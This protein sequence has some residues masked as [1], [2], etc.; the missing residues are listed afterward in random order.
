MQQR[1]AD[2]GQHAQRAIGLLPPAR[3]VLRAARRALRSTACRSPCWYSSATG[4]TVGQEPLLP[5]FVLAAL[6]PLVRGVTLGACAD[7]CAP[8]AGCP[9]GPRS[10]TRRGRSSSS[11]SLTTSRCC[12]CT[13][14]GRPTATAQTGAPSTSCRSACLRAKAPLFGVG[15]PNPLGQARASAPRRGKR[16]AWRHVCGGTACATQCFA[17]GSSG[18]RHCD[19]RDTLMTLPGPFGALRLH[20]ASTVAS[21]CPCSTRA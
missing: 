15:A 19:T 21:A 7:A 17:A 3:Q 20:H 9:T 5:L 16:C 2:G 12:T 10:R 6:L 14:S 11:R 18:A 8:L 1:G 4:L 13:S